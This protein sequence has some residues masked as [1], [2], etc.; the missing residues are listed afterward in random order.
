V[1]WHLSSAR[2][3][4]ST[5]P[6]DAARLLGALTNMGYRASE[7]DRAISALGDSVG[8][9]PIAELLREALGH[10]TR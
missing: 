8:K 9:R 1:L 4:R 3:A 2:P 5:Q 7:A 6:D 10:L